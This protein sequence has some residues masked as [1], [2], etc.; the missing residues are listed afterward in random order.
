LFCQRKWHD[1]DDKLFI[2]FDV[3]H[4][5]FARAV[6]AVDGREHDARWTGCDAAEKTK[7]S[8]VCD[9]VIGDGGYPSDRARHD[10]RDHGVIDGRG[11]HLLRIKDHSLVLGSKCTKKRP[12]ENRRPQ[13]PNLESRQI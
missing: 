6:R 12:T 7:R 4:C 13:K 2:V 5:V 1:V 11:R 9:A 8:K 10:R 3:D